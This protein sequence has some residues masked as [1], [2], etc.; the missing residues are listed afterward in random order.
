MADDLA[1]LEDWAAPLLARLEPSARRALAATI[2]RDLRRSQVQ[3][4][5]AQRNPEG[6][7][8]EPRKPQRASR[9]G[10]PGKVRAKMFARLRTAKFLRLSTDPN[11]ASIDFLGRAERI[12]R[13][14]QFGE[15]DRVQDGGPEVTYPVRQLLGF[16][17]EERDRIKDLL[18]EHLAA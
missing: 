3:R 8:Y 6:D 15:R 18:L 2:G 9:R 7:A 11:A 1:A 16:T 14:H 5:A 10:Q 12:A 17:D 4:I 13:V